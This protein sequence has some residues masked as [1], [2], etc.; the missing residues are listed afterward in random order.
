MIVQTHFNTGRKSLIMTLLFSRKLRTL[1]RNVFGFELSV[2]LGWSRTENAG[3]RPWGS[4]D[5]CPALSNW[6]HG[7]FAAFGECKMIA[8]RGS[9]QQCFGGSETERVTER[10]GRSLGVCNNLHLICFSSSPPLLSFSLYLF[11]LSE[12][13]SRLKSSGR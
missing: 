8:F 10:L 4:A 9:C 5:Q 13:V 12:N 6:H 2:V 3:E 11:C 7:R 1:C